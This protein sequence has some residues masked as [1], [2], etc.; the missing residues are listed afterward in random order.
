[1]A[2]GMVEMEVLTV[3]LGPVV[4]LDAEDGCLEAARP[5]RGQ[6]VTG[7]P[8]PRCPSQIPP[9]MVSTLGAAVGVSPHDHLAMPD[10][11]GITALSDPRIDDLSGCQPVRVEVE[12]LATATRRMVDAEHGNL[13]VK[14]RRAGPT[15]SKHIPDF[16]LS[17]SRA[18]LPAP[19]ASA[20]APAVGCSP[21]PHR[22]R[23]QRLTI[24]TLGPSED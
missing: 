5:V 11:D 12:V 2:A 22:A 18:G 16:P 7:R 24:P 13:E 23:P 20:N 19:V 4:M 3:D 9:A 1:M 15:V 17:C 14:R 8:L 6:D 21:Y 10:K